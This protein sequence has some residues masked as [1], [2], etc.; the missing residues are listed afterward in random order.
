MV[1]GSLAPP[2]SAKQERMKHE[3][4]MRSAETKPEWKLRQKYK[5]FIS[6]LMRQTTLEENGNYN[7][8]VTD[9]RCH[10]H[11]RR[12]PTS[13][14][15]SWASL[16]QEPAANGS[17]W[18]PRLR[19]QVDSPEEMGPRSLPGPKPCSELVPRALPHPSAPPLP[20]P[21]LSTH[22]STGPEVPQMLLIQYLYP[23]IICTFFF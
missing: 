8:T 17:P 5:M 19:Q 21:Q 3:E 1:H 20:S 11:H 14:V 23:T 2:H 18:E 6:S 15:A 9:G 10:W 12:I 4:E 16:L 7:L 22:S 13:S